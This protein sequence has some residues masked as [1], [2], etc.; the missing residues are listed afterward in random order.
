MNKNKFCSFLSLCP[1]VIFP[2]VSA[3]C[4]KIRTK[5]ELEK[6]IVSNLDSYSLFDEQ[7]IFH[8]DN[9]PKNVNITVVDDN[10][11]KQEI[12]P[13][14][15]IESEILYF[16]RWWAWPIDFN[17]GTDIN[18]YQT[19]IESEPKRDIGFD[20]KRHPIKD[21]KYSWFKYY[22]SS[23]N[24]NFLFNFKTDLF[25]GNLNEFQPKFQDFSK[26]LPSKDYE[27]KDFN[28]DNFSSFNHYDFYK[29]TKQYAKD[30]SLDEN[31]KYLF[32]T[33]INLYGDYERQD[34]YGL[35]TYKKPEDNIFYWMPYIKDNKL[36]F[37]RMI[38][39]KKINILHSKSATRTVS[40]KTMLFNVEKLKEILKLSP[41][42]EFDFSKHIVIEN[43]TYYQNF[44]NE[45]KKN[46]IWT[47]EDLLKKYSTNAKEKKYVEEIIRVA[48]KPLP[49]PDNQ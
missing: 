39:N 38:K 16:E 2:L 12:L 41:Q 28:F 9:S 14:K 5:E 48:E 29:N 31:K 43:N 19:I 10:F 11:F 37:S 49:L 30:H 47:K 13:E 17:K 45:Y 21:H 34:E 36:Y 22:H 8:Q 27:G 20:S 26:S 25:Q 3:Q 6:E 42:E 35:A 7:L 40:L 15:I 23:Y 33:G 1:L 24:D 44:S 18:S 46:M 32:F 4:S